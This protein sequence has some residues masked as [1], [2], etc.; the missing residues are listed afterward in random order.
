VLALSQD[1]NVNVRRSIAGHPNLPVPRLLEMVEDS[2][3]GIVERAAGNTSLP[4]EAMH[5]LL[6]VAGIPRRE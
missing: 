1:S 2:D 3:L 4:A 6:D 5:R